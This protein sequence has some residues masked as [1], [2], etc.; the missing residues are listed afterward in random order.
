MALARR[1]QCQALV[2]T[3]LSAQALQAPTVSRP[4]RHISMSAAAGVVK[5]AP[6]VITID[7]IGTLVR[8]AGPEGLLY[9]DALLAATGLMLPRPDIFQ[10]VYEQAYAAAGP[11][12]GTNS[13][14]AE[15]WWKKVTKA[16]YDGVLTAEPVVYDADE[17]ALY[18]SA[19]DDIFRSLHDDLTLSDEAWVVDPDA[20][21]LLS[22][23]R[24]WRDYGGPRIVVAT[25]HFDDRLEQLLA[26]L[27]GGDCV[28]ATFDHVVTGTG[29]ASCFDI[30]TSTMDV[31]DAACKH[32][33]VAD[34]GR[35]PYDTLV[36]DPRDYENER[37]DDARGSLLDLLDDWGLERA[38]GDDV[39]VT[40][41]TY[42]VYD[43]EYP[44][45]DGENM[46][47]A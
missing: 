5:A 36:V 14:G 18:E 16:T 21:R 29:Q 1:R 12:F 46:E 2:A 43:A 4:R 42:S 31:Q 25:D 23:L 39:V 32:V 11:R 30:T 10:G 20:P 8:R 3:L 24:Q 47:Q 26:N 38:E 17:L 40:S 45:F 19:F 9:R 13:E 33:A 15:A 27:L 44:G 28:A 22:A 7:P 37:S 34:D 6:Q 35:C 41:R